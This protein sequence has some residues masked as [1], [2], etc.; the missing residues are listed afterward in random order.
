MGELCLLDIRAP[1]GELLDEL[2][3]LLLD[4]LLLD[5]LLDC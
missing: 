3:A 2:L 1:L 4:E 5:V